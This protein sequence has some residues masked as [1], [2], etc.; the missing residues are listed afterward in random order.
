MWLEHSKGEGTDEVREVRRLDGEHLN[1]KKKIYMYIYT[2]KFN[3]LLSLFSE[4]E[5]IFVAN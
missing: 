3:Y 1:L 4:S 2:H 5:N